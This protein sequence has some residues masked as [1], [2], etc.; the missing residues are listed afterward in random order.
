MNLQE[1]IFLHICVGI[2]MD[3]NANDVI[4]RVRDPKFGT[5]PYEDP[6]VRITSLFRHVYYDTQILEKTIMSILDPSTVLH[7]LFSEVVG[8]AWQALSQFHMR[9]GQNLCPLLWQV[10]SFVPLLVS[11]ACLW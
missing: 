1:I 5:E 9:K 11:K 7:N 3:S 2:F 10:Y 6:R 8:F 4:F